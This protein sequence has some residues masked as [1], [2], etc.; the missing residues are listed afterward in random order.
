MLDC[1]AP[2]LSRGVCAFMF[3]FVCVCVVWCVFFG[4]CFF[5]GWGFGVAMKFKLD[6]FV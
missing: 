4:V 1:I 6:V 3:V 2:S 5:V